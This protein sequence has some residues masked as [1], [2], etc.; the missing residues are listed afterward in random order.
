M[1]SISLCDC[2]YE[3]SLSKIAIFYFINV[4]AAKL[5]SPAGQYLI[6]KG[7]EEERE[8]ER[9]RERERKDEREKERKDKREIERE[10]EREKERKRERKK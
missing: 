5:G 9:S 6:W 1:L 10:K 7:G 3:I 4:V 8:R 2:I